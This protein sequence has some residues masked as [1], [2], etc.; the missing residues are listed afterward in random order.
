M[1]S[2]AE[3]QRIILE[4]ARPLAAQTAPL[5]ASA[6]GL[7]L[8]EDVASDTDMP[9]HDK[10]LMDGYAV[11]CTDLREGRATLTVVEEVTAGKVPTRSVGPGQATRIMTGAPIPEGADAVVMVERSQS[12]GNSVRVE[13]APPKPGQNI[14]TRGR[15]MR[16]GDVVL[17]AGAILRP[18][19][20]GLLATVGRSAVR[21]VTA[22]RVAVVTTGDEVV[23]PG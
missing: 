22:P 8:A 10:A 13:D 2:V 7:V 12:E 1:R 18:Q 4:H 16:Q 3:A 6:L 11:R 21:V 15:E 20:F 23:E 5:S 14:L 19:E 17:K 9:P